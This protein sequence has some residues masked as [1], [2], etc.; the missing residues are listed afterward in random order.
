M[1]ILRRRALDI[2]LGIVLA[3]SFAAILLGQEN[4][5][6][7]I[8]LCGVAPC[9]KFA[10]SHAWEK[11]AYDVGIASVVSLFFYALIVRI[12]EHQRKRRLKRSFSKHYEAFKRNCI[13]V[14]LGVA[15]LT[16]PRKK[17]EELMDENKFY[18]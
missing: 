16:S 6:V 4:P 10:H 9:P 15:D 2:S 14:M 7:R 18:D 1:N 17:Q 11:I 8:A 3:L 12:P 13:M 5:F